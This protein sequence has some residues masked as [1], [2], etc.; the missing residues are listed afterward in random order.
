MVEKIQKGFLAILN[1][2]KQEILK[3]NGKGF[4]IW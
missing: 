2:V 4:S 1:L 3:P